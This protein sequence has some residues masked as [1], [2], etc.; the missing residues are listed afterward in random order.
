[1]V[2]L[3]TCSVLLALVV[4]VVGATMLLL[5]L[6]RLGVRFCKDRRVAPPIIDPETTSMIAIQPENPQ[7]EEPGE[8]SPTPTQPVADYTHCQRE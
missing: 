5:H 7:N 3:A 4:I 2:A 8:L 6:R 1:M